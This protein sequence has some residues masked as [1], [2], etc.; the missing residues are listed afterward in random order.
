MISLLNKIKVGETGEK[1]QE[2]ALGVR[3]VGLMQDEII[4]GGV[5]ESQWSVEVVFK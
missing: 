5:C 2:K 4:E 1:K 3:A